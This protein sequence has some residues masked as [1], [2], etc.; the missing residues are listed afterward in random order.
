VDTTDIAIPYYLNRGTSDFTSTAIGN[1]MN[2]TMTNNNN[3]NN[4][5]NNAQKPNILIFW[6]NQAR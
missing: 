6:D 2:N 4:V 1:N 3:I 5:N